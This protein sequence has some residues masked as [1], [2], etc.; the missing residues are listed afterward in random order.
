[1]KNTSMKARLRCHSLNLLFCARKGLRMIPGKHRRPRTKSQSRTKHEPTSKLTHD[2]NRQFL[3]L[4]V[5]NVT[6]GHAHSSRHCHWLRDTKKSAQKV[7]AFTACQEV[8]SSGI[9]TTSQT[10]VAASRDASQDIIILSTA[11]VKPLRFPQWKASQTLSRA[12]LISEVIQESKTLDFEA[13]DQHGSPRFQRKTAQR[14]RSSIVLS[15]ETSHRVNETLIFTHDKFRW[16]EFAR[17]YWNKILRVKF[18]WGGDPKRV[19][20][21]IHKLENLVPLPLKNF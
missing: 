18:W 20:E 3:T 9:A 8:T 12:T 6:F 11:H 4:K 17:F 15:D 16:G 14:R 2:G 10:S 21:E 7:F 1:M 13:Q 5:S 19:R